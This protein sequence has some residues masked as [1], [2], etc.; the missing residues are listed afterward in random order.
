MPVPYRFSNARF[1][2]AG[3]GAK[4]NKDNNPIL[5]SNCTVKNARFGD[6]L[7]IIVGDGTTI[8]KSSKEFDVDLQQEVVATST[9]TTTKLISLSDL[10]D[11]PAYTKELLLQLKLLTFPLQKY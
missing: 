10:N 8:E 2:D 11:Q 5:L 1:T 4:F 7:E 6:G 9:T 3:T